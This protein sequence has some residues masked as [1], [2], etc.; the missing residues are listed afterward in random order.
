MNN[1]DAL[2]RQARRNNRRRFLLGLAVLLLV[3]IGASFL[4]LAAWLESARTWVDSHL[5]LGALLFAGV[6]IILTVAM[7][8]G[9]L[10]MASA[11]YLFGLPV[12]LP[13]ASVCIGCGAGLAALV[14]RTF[15]R[16]WLWQRFNTDPRFVTIDE[17][18]ARKGFLIVLLTRLSLLMPFNLLN[19]IYGLSRIPLP[20]M[21]M[22]TWIGMTPAVLLYTYLGSIAANV[23][24]LMSQ[25][26][27]NPWAS[28][29]VLISGILVVVAATWVVHRTATAALRAELEQ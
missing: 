14:Y 7:V 29:A 5:L 3:I 9:S 22:A 26:F 25:E 1:A 23:E 27:A 17:A 21:A 13:L 4:P 20:T 10:L 8:P 15:A 6:F 16:E 11:G 28:R 12:G 24:Q 19:I 2:D 18:V